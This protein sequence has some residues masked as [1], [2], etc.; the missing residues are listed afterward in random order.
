MACSG[1]T[2]RGQ[3]GLEGTSIFQVNF[4]LAIL[5]TRHEN[6]GSGYIYLSIF[7][8]RVQEGGEASGEN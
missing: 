2:P 4:V 6:W 8:M 5:E 7:S 3:K 1:S